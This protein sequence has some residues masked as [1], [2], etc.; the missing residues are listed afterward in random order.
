MEEYT[1]KCPECN[2]IITHKTKYSRN[3]CDHN[4][5]PCRSCSSKIRYKN[6]GSTIDIINAEVKSGER[7][8]GFQNHVHSIES[9]NLISQSHLNNS[10]SYKTPEF[11]DKM[12]IIS[13][14][15]NN[16]MYGKTVFDI[17]VEKYGIEEANKRDSNRRKKW[18][19]K[20][21]GKNN[22]MYGKE[23]PQKSG[24]GISGWYNSFFF[25]SLHELKFILIC[26]RFKL[27]IIS[28][29]K[30]RIKYLSYTGNER[31][32]SPDFIVDNKYLIEVKP[33]KLHNTPLNLLKFA[34]VIEY[35]KENE[36][37]FKVLDFGIV[38]QY[39]LNELIAKNIVK[40]N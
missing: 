39:Q 26:E 7:K 33:K 15:E 9:K 29:E 2:E 14:G 32:Y 23:P 5:R 3:Q 11:R 8:N 36:L 22:P 1:R 6:Y 25:R 4:K 38:P 13:S 20:S 31:T 17:W 35:C 19:S 10:D 21:K 18:S 30:I 27:K 37:K 16:S 40:L 34:S 28:A 12:R 24:N